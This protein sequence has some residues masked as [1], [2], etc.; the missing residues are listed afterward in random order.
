[1]N[2]PR[3]AS[4]ATFALVLTTAPVWG[5]KCTGKAIETCLRDPHRLERLYEAQARKM[6]GKTCI[7]VAHV[8]YCHKKSPPAEAI[9]HF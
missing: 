4:L 8:R 7:L 9:G 6:A 5:L 1:M 2:M 3:L